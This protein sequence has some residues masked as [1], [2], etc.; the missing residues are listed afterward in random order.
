MGVTNFP[1]G[2]TFD[3]TKN[4]SMASGSTVPVTGTAGYNPGCTFIKSDVAL[5]QAAQWINAGTAA[6]CLFVPVGPTY[7]YGIK[8]AEGPVASAGGDT[9]EVITRSGM[10]LSTDL[11]I[12]NHEVSDDNDQIVAATVTDNTITI[13]G[14]ADP[15]TAHG[16]N[17]ALLRNRCIPEWDIV[18]AGT[19]VT[20]GGAAA[21]AITVAGVLATDMAFVNYGSTN[22]TDVISDV[23]CT[24]N[25]ITVTCSA[26]PST[27]HSLHYVV[28]RPRGTFKPSHYIAYAGKHTTVGGAA[29][30]AVTIAGALATDIPIVIYSTT[31]DTDSILKVVMTADTMTVTCSA[32]PST[33]HAFT[34]MIL[35]AY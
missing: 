13:T 25:T 10:I 5:G 33:A 11:G 3:T 18:A 17:Y 32:D 31:N 34:Y 29:A 27:A 1:N 35:R 22:D 20:A 8:L 16:Y 4:K 23:V 2:I 21:E 30:E 9:T 24:A 28:I 6:S 7:G 14:G 26:D 15:S 19:H 12:V